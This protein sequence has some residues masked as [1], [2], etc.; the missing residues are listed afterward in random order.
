MRSAAVLLA[1]WG[2]VFT[3]PLFTTPVAAQIA[4][5]Q[6]TGRVVDQANALSAD[7]ERALS[8]ASARFEQATTN[9]L[10]IVTL[11]SLQG[12]TIEDF[13]YQLGREWGIGR[14]G[15]NNGAL[16]IVAPQERTVR[17]EV[18]Y[19][20]EGTLT[21]AVA[22]GIIE[23]RIIPRFRDGDFNGGVR[24]GADAII[25]VLSGDTATAS[26][27][28]EAASR[29]IKAPVPNESIVPFVVI[30]IAVVI[31]MLRSSRRRRRL[32]PWGMIGMGG[33]GGFGGG[34]SG[35][36]SGGGGFSGGGG[37]FGGGG[38]SGRW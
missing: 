34:G 25:A 6:L 1:I 20:L 10:V 21:D 17:I 9:Q 24:A 19:G 11:P 28:A 29:K 22:K 27:M 30:A 18:G 23:Q 7:T 4:F 12:Q 3:A 14:A 5:P 15:K 31:L 37:S 35:G 36:G 33:L 26:R 2:V 8:D 32:G 13:G 16:L 38:A